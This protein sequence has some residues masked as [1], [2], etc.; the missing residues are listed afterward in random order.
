MI[1]LSKEFGRNVAGRLETEPV[2][3]FTPILSDG[4]LRP[5]PFWF[6]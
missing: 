2:N 4:S 6:Y 1:D 3:R 5:N